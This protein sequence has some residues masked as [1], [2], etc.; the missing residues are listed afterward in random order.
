MFSHPEVDASWLIWSNKRKTPI[1][2]FYTTW[3]REFH[4]LDTI[5]QPL[6]QDLL[7][8]FPKGFN[9][10]SSSSKEDLVVVATKWGDYLYNTRERVVE[11][12]VH[13]PPW[14]KNLPE[15]EPIKYTS[16]DGFTIHGYLTLPKGSDGKNLPLVVKPHGGPW[17]R[18]TLKYDPEVQFLVNR[19]YA[20]LQM[21][22]R[23]S[24]G[25]GK[26][27][28]IAGFKQWGRKMQDDITDG[29][30][31]LIDQGIADRNRIA[32]YGK[33]Y[34]G[35][36]ALA[37]LAFTPDLYACGVDY[38]GPSN[39]FTLLN[40]L[41]PYWNLEQM[42]EKIGHPEKDQQLLREISPLFHVDNIKVPLFVVHGVNDPRV[43][44]AESDQIVKALEDRGVEFPIWLKKM[45][46][47]SF[48]MRKIDWSFIPF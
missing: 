5:Y 42:Y 14:L 36:A 40:S 1:A 37:G 29:V 9:I 28:W 3:K 31:Y 47:T 45:R 19:G 27:F 15:P 7:S 17:E 23:G 25:Y 35:Y 18:D 34:G 11:Q 33:S 10:V 12:I 39:L 8:K 43:K 44:I 4:V 38:V 20:V 46:V 2:A 48:A 24:V 22:F 16:R 32:I 6:F 26:K 13:S 21:N 41:P 30:Q